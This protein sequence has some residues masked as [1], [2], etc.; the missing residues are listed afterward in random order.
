M[1][2]GKY[3][4]GISM[5]RKPYVFDNCILHSMFASLMVNSVNREKNRSAKT[6]VVFQKWSIFGV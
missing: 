6:S 2:E 1:A 4:Y 3:V 5:S